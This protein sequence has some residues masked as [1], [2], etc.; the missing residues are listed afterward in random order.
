M[1]LNFFTFLPVATVPMLLLTV[2]VAITVGKTAPTVL[3]RFSSKNSF[4]STARVAHFAEFG[5]D[6]V[7]LRLA[8]LPSSLFASSNGHG[9]PVQRFRKAGYIQ[10]Q[11]RKGVLSSQEKHPYPYWEIVIAR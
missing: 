4:A 10:P 9:A 5:S 1:L 2:L 7:S 11:L 8:V 3:A 6:F